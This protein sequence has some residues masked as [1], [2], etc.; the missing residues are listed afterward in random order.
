MEE[1]TKNK[2]GTLRHIFSAIAGDMLDPLSIF[3]EEA[4]KSSPAPPPLMGTPSP[5]STSISSKYQK[6]NQNSATKQLTPSNS[7]NDF[8]SALFGDNNSNSIKIDE[9]NYNSPS[10]S[11]DLYSTNDLK[12]NHSQHQENS[13]YKIQLEE[14]Y[15]SFLTGEES[16]LKLYDVLIQIPSGKY[17]SVIL[18]LT[19]YRLV[20][21]PSSS[22]LKILSHNNH[23]F[24]SWLHIPL[25]CI[26]RIEREKRTKDYRNS[27]NLN[28]QNIAVT[29]IISCKD[30]RQY[31]ITLDTKSYIDSK[32]ADSTS[33]STSN[34]PITDSI[35]ERTISL[36]ARYAFPNNS[37]YLFAYSHSISIY[38]TPEIKE[39]YNR[40]QHYDPHI[41]F[42]RQGITTEFL[43]QPSSFLRFSYVNAHFKLCTSYPQVLMVPNH[44]TDDE[45]FIVANFRSEQRIPALTWMDSNTRVSLWRSSQP[46]CGVSGSYCRNVTSAMANR[47]AGA[48][49]ESNTNYPNT[50]LE[51]MNIGNIHTMRETAWECASVI[52]FRRT[53]VLDGK[54]AIDLVCS[55]G[56]F[57]KSN[58]TVIEDLIRNT[59]LPQPKIFL[60]YGEGS[61][62]TSSTVSATGAIT[63]TTNVTE[64]T[65]NSNNKNNNRKSTHTHG[66]VT[67]THSSTP[68]SVN[69]M[70]DRML[71]RGFE[72]EGAQ[73]TKDHIADFKLIIIQFKAVILHNESWRCRR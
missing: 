46:K 30:V 39:Q 17:I 16:V 71:N 54:K 72:N 55:D 18:H 41:E 48:G 62:S 35:I 51:F 69:A 14:Q 44:I 31:R 57:D 21:I 32:P 33:T 37:K 56:N 59:H 73:L 66:T 26:D 36:I 45:L 5:P 60:T 42:M 27:S 9:T 12:S 24:H 11:S 49:Y 34:I 22:Q 19:N 8:F 50:K 47:A 53:P 13:Q 15:F 1:G 70:V 23:S 43:M 25:M 4:A 38:I 63:A 3:A 20:F 64:E 65:H 68:A 40:L 28:I 52:H 10:V 29:I 2:G 67:A 7:S 61:K 6:Q 58:K